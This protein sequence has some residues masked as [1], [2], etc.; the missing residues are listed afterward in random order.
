[1]FTVIQCRTFCFPASCLKIEIKICK[2][3]ILPPVLHDSE[4]GSFTLGEEHSLRAFDHSV[5]GGTFGPER[6]DVAR[7]W[8]RLHD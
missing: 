6:E 2:T 3:I 7:D 4:T 5:L 8:R 1:M